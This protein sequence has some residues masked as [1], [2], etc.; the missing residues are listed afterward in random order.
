MQLKLFI[1]FFFLLI[2]LFNSQKKQQPMKDC[3][4][5]T[6]I[7]STFSKPYYNPSNSLF[8]KSKKPSVFSVSNGIVSK[9]IRNGDLYSLIIKNE[10]LFYIYSNIVSIPKSIIVGKYI[11][12]RNLIGKGNLL[13]NEYSIELQIYNKTDLLSNVQEYIQCK[14]IFVT[15]SLPTFSQ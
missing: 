15:Q 11:K 7:D 9:I 14:K 6:V 5:Y 10:N 4:C 12:K 1:C 2:G 3:L 8:I 13:T